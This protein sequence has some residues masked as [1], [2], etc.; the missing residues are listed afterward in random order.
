MLPSKMQVN[1]KLLPIKGHYFFFNAGTAPLVPYLTTYAR[2]LGFS[3]TTVGLIYTVLPICGL[4]AKPLFGVIADRFKL[5]KSIFIL[6]QFVTIISFSA[7]YFVPHNRPKINVELNCGPAGTVLTSCYKDSPSLDCKIQATGDLNVTSTCKMECNMGNPRMWETVCE[8]W[9]LPQYCYSNTDR[10]RYTSHVTNVTLKDDCAYFSANSVILDGLKFTPRCRIGQNYVDVNEPCSL[11]CTNENLS[12]VIGR[13]KAN[14]TCVDRHLNYRLCTNSSLADLTKQNIESDCQADCVLDKKTPWRL[15][16]ICEGWHAD[17]TETCY[18]KTSNDEPFPSKLSFTATLKLSS[19][20]SVEN[21]VYIKLKN[22]IMDNGTIHYPYCEMKTDYQNTSQL[23]ESN[24]EMNCD[25]TMVNEIFEESQESTEVEESSQFT[26][27]FWMFFMFMI[28]SWVGQAVVVTFADAI[29]FN[30]LGTEVAQY[31][32]QRLWG[33]VGWGIFSFLTGFL[34]DTF[35]DGAYKDYTVA[36]VLMFVFMMGDVIVSCFLKTD[37]TK[38]SL[39]ILGDVGTLLTSLPTFVFMMWTVAVGLCTGLLWNFLFW[40]LEDV[41]RL[42]CDSV[43]YIKTL[44]GL[45]SAIQTFF[46]EIPFLFV[47]GY[48]LKK[49][50]HVKMMSLVLFAFGVRFIL[51]SFLT[52][53]WWILPIEM[54]QGITFGMFYPTMTSY[55]SI[56]SPPG[57]ETTIQ[58]LVGAVFEGVGAS[59]G[60]FIGGQLYHHYQGWITFRIYGIGSLV[61]CAL[62]LTVQYVFKDKIQRVGLSQGY[63]SVFRNEQQNDMVFMLQDMGDRNS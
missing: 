23:F 19:M 41:S 63:V 20:I 31:G 15:M 49:V 8:Y 43:M 62:H 5:Q 34:I 48:I 35:S 33:S 7:I 6:F 25:N 17:V 10:I 37:S 21:C 24:C 2:Q 30:L 42:S 9:H 4:I 36:F 52:N 47:S 58:G 55:A 29:C 44:Q 32:K 54:L 59:L 38:M 1:K 57:T 11:N 60:S 28:I 56:V 12:S 16:E 26:S 22:I 51:Y 39:N 27:Q 46:G 50:G 40:L 53:A 14:M 3:S 45:V 13:E 18:P 61:C